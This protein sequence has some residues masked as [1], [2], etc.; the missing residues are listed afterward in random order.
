MTPESKSK[1]LVQKFYNLRSIETMD[2]KQRSVGF[3][4][5][6][7]SAIICVEEIE[8]SLQEYDQ[9]NSTY[10]LQN[11]DRDFGYWSSVKTHL[12][13]SQIHQ[14]SNKKDFTM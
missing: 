11:M 3:G 10:E 4:I 12:I 2:D 9:R 5:A 14:V 7:Q 1:A 6:R 13:N 8:A